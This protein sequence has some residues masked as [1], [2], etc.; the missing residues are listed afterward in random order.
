MSKKVALGESS[1]S[2]AITV[3]P[4]ALEERM[5]A[6]EQQVAGLITAVNKVAN[7]LARCNGSI[8]RKSLNKDGKRRWLL[9]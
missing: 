1:H 9:H 7:E 6:L 8:E 4:T 5:L 2:K 3:E